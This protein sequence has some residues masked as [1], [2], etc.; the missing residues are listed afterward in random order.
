M[1]PARD[2]R[3]LLDTLAD[4]TTGPTPNARRIHAQT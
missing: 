2:V 1:T 4:R 3:Q